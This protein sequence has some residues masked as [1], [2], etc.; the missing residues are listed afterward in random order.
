MEEGVKVTKLSV[1]ILCRDDDAGVVEQAV[2][3][4]LVECPKGVWCS[5]RSDETILPED[6][7][8][9]IFAKERLS[10]ES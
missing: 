6:H 5:F 3:N 1:S 8:M 10:R 2:A 9:A 4:A 7:P